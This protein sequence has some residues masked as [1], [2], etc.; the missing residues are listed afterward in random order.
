MVPLC[1]AIPLIRGTTISSDTRAV[2]TNK[3]KVIK[4]RKNLRP[5]DS[6]NLVKDNILSL[7]LRGHTTEV[8]FYFNEM[9]CSFSITLRTT[10]K[11]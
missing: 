3:I 5:Y 11:F 9:L 7:Y 10:L 6:R 1:D 2:M 8:A 4:L